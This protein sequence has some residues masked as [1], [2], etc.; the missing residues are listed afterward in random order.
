MNLAQKL[1]SR[2]REER[3]L[4]LFLGDA[5]A[6]VWIHGHL[7]DCQDGCQKFVQESKV[8]SMGGAANAET[9]IVHWRVK[10]CRYGSPGVWPTKYRF[11]GSDG[12]II[13]RWDTPVTETDFTAQRLASLEVLLQASAVLISDYDKGFLTPQFVREVI[14]NCQS[15]KIPCVADAKREPALYDGAIL[16]CNSTYQLNHNQELS[17]SVYDSDDG[18]SLVVTCGPDIPACWDKGKLQKGFRF[19]PAVPCVNHIGAGDCFAAHLTLALAY[20]F[21][22]KEAATIA[23]SAGRVYVQY[24][25][26]RPPQ[27]EEVI[28]DMGGVR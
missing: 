13:M 4:I 6:D 15:L 16:K 5:I 22:L 27:P 11:V 20:G 21:T 26:N 14:L 23:Y 28:A 18:R 7:E 17:R 12:K 8:L 9:S 19:L 3:K 2:V 10:T 24:P 1:L 25:H